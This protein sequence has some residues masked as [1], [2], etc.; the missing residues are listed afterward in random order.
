MIREAMLAGNIK[1]Q[2]F[3]DPYELIE[4]PIELEKEKVGS[5]PCKAGLNIIGKMPKKYE[6]RG[7]TKT[8]ITPSVFFDKV[9]EHTTE[10]TTL[11]KDTAAGDPMEKGLV[12][13]GKSTPWI[14]PKLI[15]MA[16][17]DVKNN[18]EINVCGVSSALYRRKLTYLE[19]VQ[20]VEGDEF[21][22]PINRKTS[23]GFPYVIEYNHPKGKREAFG[24]EEWKMDT[25]QAK[26][27]EEDVLELEQ[28]CREGRQSGVYWTDTLK[29]ERR[30]IAKV[31][32]GKT[33]VFCA[34]PV[35]FT[36]LFRMYFLG[37]AAWIMRNRNHNEVSTGTNVY[38]YDWNNIVRKLR[39][40]GKAS[41]GNINVVAGD[42]ENFDGS[43]SSQILWA[44][45]ESIQEWYDDGAENAQIR[46][47]LWAHIVHAMHVNEGIVY[48]AT[49]SQPSGCPITAILNSIYNSIVI[50]I[51]F[52]MAAMD[53]EQRQGIRT[54]ELA[55]MTMFNRCVA[56]I[57]YGDDNLIAIM[58]SILE[59]F[60]Q[61]II[62]EK[63][64]KIGH[65]YT[66]EAKTGEI[67]TVRD[68]SEVAYLKRKFVWSEGA[69]RYIAPLNLDV[70]LEIVQ[71][72]KQG[73]QKDE[74]TLAN[75]DITMRELS[76]HGE[77]IYK[78]YKREFEHVC[79]M[80]RIPF[81]FQD[82]YSVMRRS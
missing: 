27:I 42:F 4:E 68:L 51:V 28:R 48:S 43:L 29:D 60:N 35:H 81:R 8:K 47:T 67:Y 78:K 56:C 39:S 6:I 70:V 9:T 41:N 11:R 66:D 62:T 63:F 1:L 61:V 82:W 71:W 36:I 14:E 55:N 77:K 2:V 73:L 10:P 20:G 64:A 7:A 45:F 22:A 17:A 74:I 44:I 15:K 34:G 5:V 54:G 58:E 26:K 76:L 65:V 38:S 19:G 3:S 80:H 59:W 40:R 33:R 75:L 25:P 31:R 21:M 79:Q 50:R 32:A 52:L 46:R 18:Y 49:H 13:F 30:P 37:F 53:E 23:L 24:E 12:K 16:T 72:T 69:Q 57:S